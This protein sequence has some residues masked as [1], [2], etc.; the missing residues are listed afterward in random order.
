MGISSVTS[1]SLLPG[2]NIASS[3]NVED[4][5]QQ[6]CWHQLVFD[7]H[8]TAMLSYVLFYSFILVHVMGQCH[9]DEF[10]KKIDHVNQVSTYIVPQLTVILKN[11]SQS[12]K[13]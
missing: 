3:I 4:L 13:C 9:Y 2:V 12:I 6:F 8:S 11:C 7:L 5:Y 10:R 1:F